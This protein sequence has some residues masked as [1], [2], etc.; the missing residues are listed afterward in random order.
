RLGLPWL[1]AYCE[2]GT[3]I[4]GPCVDPAEAGCVAFVELRRRAALRDVTDFDL[5]CRQ[6][7]REKRTVGQPLLTNRHL[8]L[9]TPMVVGEVCSYLNA[10]DT[11]HTKRAALYL[12]LDTLHCQRHRFLPEPECPVCGSMVPDTPEAARIE[13]QSRPKLSP[14]TYRTRSLKARAK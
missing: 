14:Y 13:L 7:E 10:R 9:L 1:R 12:D 4:I 5:S 11:M 8:E 6:N 3:G 2:F